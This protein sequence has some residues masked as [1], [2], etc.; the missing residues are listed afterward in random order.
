MRCCSLTAA[1]ICS[2]SSVT[3][4]PTSSPPSTDLLGWAPS[5]MVLL[6]DALGDAYSGS[7]STDADGT[8]TCWH[9]VN[10]S[11]G[12]Y[13]AARRS[14]DH[15][16][17][18]SAPVESFGPPRRDW[19]DPF[20][21]SVPGEAGEHM[22]LAAPTNWADGAAGRST[23]E[24]YHRAE[25]TEGWRLRQVIGPWSAAGVMWEVP[26]LLPDPAGEGQW[27]LIVSLLDRRSGE[28]G[29]SVRRWRGRLVDGA[30]VRSDA[31]DDEGEPLDAGPDFYAAM[32]NSPGGWP[33]EDRVF[34]GWASAWGSARDF[35]WPGFA[36]GP[37]SLPRRLTPRGS[38]PL[39]AIMSAFSERALAVPPAGMAA[40]TLPGVARLD[41]A[42]HNASLSVTI[43][44][45]RLSAER[46]GG[47]AL[48]WANNIARR[49]RGSTLLTLFI[50]GPLIE[51]HI[52]PDDVWMTVALPNDGTPFAVGLRDGN[53]GTIPLD[54]RT[55]PG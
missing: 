15:G 39:S 3:M 32:A 48:A 40:A 20:V 12:Q 49:E 23:L 5:G 37:I 26:L 14:H 45:E 8:L 28:T 55:L 11:E 6:P 1:I 21:F 43:A 27:S 29:C 35:P 18:W 22:L 36:G 10:G 53:V 47:S 4:R 41:I 34:V 7:I 24:L 31:A 33:G 2:R 25:A 30:F 54:W 13:Q 46:R 52:A 38:A 17:S 50:D 42:G 44:P 9:T 19:R 51:L 16:A